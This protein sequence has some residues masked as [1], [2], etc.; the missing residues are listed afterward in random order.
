MYPKFLRL[1]SQMWIFKPHLVCE[2]FDNLVIRFLLAVLRCP[3]PCS[4]C[5]LTA[6]SV[7]TRIH[8]FILA[9]TLWFV[10]WGWKK[11]NIFSTGS[12]IIFCSGAPPS[13]L[14]SLLYH[15][16]PYRMPIMLLG[17]R[18]GEGIGGWARE[19]AVREI[20][21]IIQ[22]QSLKGKCVFQAVKM[23]N[24]W[25]QILTNALV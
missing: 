11:K 16:V 5:N 1:P 24:G 13:P 2:V 15:T 8:K 23:I 14:Q 18:N 3:C 12:L 21:L 9:E 22:I 10:R 20:E 4:V 7:C 17:E 25:E 6:R 19:R